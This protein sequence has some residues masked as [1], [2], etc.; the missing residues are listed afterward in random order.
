MQAEKRISI[1]VVRTIGEQAF[2]LALVLLSFS[3]V[4][5]KKTEPSEP[6]PRVKRIIQLEPLATKY[7]EL[8]DG[9]RYG[10]GENLYNRLVTLLKNDGRFV[11]VVK[12]GSLTGATKILGA[13][14]ATGAEEP[15]PYDPSD[16]LHFEFQ[17]FIAAEYSASVEGLTFLHGSRALRNFSG[18]RES[19]KTPWNDGGFTNTNEFP[20]RSLEFQNSWFGTT[21]D[22]IGS[23]ATNTIA[24]VDAGAEGEFNLLIAKINYRR[25]SFSASADIR[26]QL[27][28]INESATRIL[29]ISATGKGFL[30]A[31]GVSFA[32]LSV[33]FGIAKRDALKKTFDQGADLIVQAIRDELAKIP[34]RTRVENVG[35]EG[36]VINAGRREG[37]IVGDR[38]SVDG[39]SAEYIVKEVFYVG[40]IV[41]PSTGASALKGGE[42]LVLR[43]ADRLPTEQQL[44]AKI[45]RR[46]LPA[47]AVGI[48]ARNFAL[49]ANL[50]P[51]KITFDPPEFS[52]PNGDASEALSL[53]STILLPYLLWRYAQYDQE[54][55]KTAAMPS[56]S[57]I[58]A[59][60][61]ANPAQNKI[62]LAEIW[63]KEFPELKGMG[64]GVKVAI[65][66][67]G[68]DYNQENIAFA[69]KR[70][71]I[72]W[73]FFGDDARPFDDNSHGTGIASLIAGQ[74]VGNA[75]VGVAPDAQILSYR[76]FDPYGSTRSMHIYGAFARAVADGA[77]IIV[78]A[79]DTEKDSQALRTAV[80][81]AVKAGVL[82]VS[83][84][85][86]RGRDLNQSFALPASLGGNEGVISVAAIDA[87]G[88]IL[89]SPGRFSNFGANVVKIAAPGFQQKVSGPRSELLDRQGSD[90]A[91]AYV[92][93]AAALVWSRHPDWTALQVEA[94][95]LRGAQ[96]QSSLAGRVNQNRVLDLVGIFAN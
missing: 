35:S 15:A 53:K 9:A 39:S 28:L 78:T 10:M 8:E 45:V 77:R 40:A 96:S 41:E 30:F 46:A 49:E 31:L 42:V 34:F 79:W 17:P 92:A 33:E 52:L 3:F 23:A 12:E 32:E 16:R 88:G 94:A 81:M 71:Q 51:K 20:P 61:K 62:R 72:G 56:R 43:E 21:F 85:G 19:F 68:V 75:P 84:A 4:A 67:S 80:Q 11:V 70:E 89:Q 25:D 44:A 38:F 76:V 66:D 6:A 2:W 37:L 90:L 69:A 48:N 60:A 14:T 26:S 74:G 7:I 95:I 54:P 82:V 93:G 64:A 63:Q 55:A 91:A 47:G 50:E 58:L 86:D 22:P 1:R 87:N 83:A 27:H 18:F 5:C 59:K 36:I 24:G 57:G 13:N 65:I 73:D 29:P